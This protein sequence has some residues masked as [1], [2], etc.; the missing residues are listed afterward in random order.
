M[1]PTIVHD[2][3]YYIIQDSGARTYER[4]RD[5]SLRLGGRGR[6]VG[7]VISELARGHTSLEGGIA[8]PTRVDLVVRATFFPQHAAS[9]TAW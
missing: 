5:F 7:L 8:D 9:Q 6:R 2:A 3:I 4:R 1:L